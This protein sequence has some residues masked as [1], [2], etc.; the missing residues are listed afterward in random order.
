MHGYHG[1]WD[2]F[3]PAYLTAYALPPSQPE[4]DREVGGCWVWGTLILP[5]LEQRPVFDVA[6]FA[7]AFGSANGT[8]PYGILGLKA[9]RTVMQVSIA[10]FLCPS[11]GGG[12][13]PIDL[14]Y[15]S[16]PA[17]ARS[18]SSRKRWPRKSSVARNPSRRRD[19]RGRS[20]LSPEYRGTDPKRRG[21][22]TF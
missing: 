13:G 11:G 18:G 19:H 20:I 1:V 15:D 16:W 6:N 9:N 2:S 14:G 4:T 17:T 7:F 8:D 5:Y 21:S 12:E 10:T 22:L 3:P